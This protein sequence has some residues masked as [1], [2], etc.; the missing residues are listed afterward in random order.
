MKKKIK[1]GSEVV[2]TVSD[3]QGMAVARTEWLHGCFRITIQAKMKSDGKVP[4]T[5]TVDEPQV[6]TVKAKTIARGSNKSG[7]PMSFTP[8]QATV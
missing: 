5:L 8:R 1:L 6:K 4:E 2:D 7:G 3:Y